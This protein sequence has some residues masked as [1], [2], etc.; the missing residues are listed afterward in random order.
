MDMGK[1]PSTTLPRVFVGFTPNEI[2][3]TNVAE[4]SLRARARGMV[5]IHRVSRLSLTGIYTR[6]TRWEGAGLWDVISAAP[7][8][9]E[10]AIARF[11]IPYLCGYTGWA[12]FTDGDVL[13]RRSVLDLFALADDRYAV[14]CVQHGPEP[15][16]VTKK[17]GMIQTTYARKNWS[18]VMLINCGHPGIRVLEPVMLNTLTGRTLHGFTWLSDSVIGALPPEWNYLVGVNDT[19][20]DPAIVHYTLGTPD[21]PGYEHAPFADEWYAVARAAGYG[22]VQPP[23][24]AAAGV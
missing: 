21:L 18:S 20:A 2:R 14:M 12:L 6:P 17:G 24:E 10:H 22:I 23:L 11:F 16:D 9:T 4:Y 15:Q 8:S 19:Q 1:L 3:A 7:M 5:D 13:F